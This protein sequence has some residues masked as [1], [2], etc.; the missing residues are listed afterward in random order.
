MAENLLSFLMLHLWLHQASQLAIGLIGLGCAIRAK[1]PQRDATA[2]K[3]NC[4]LVRQ[5]RQWGIGF[6]VSS[7]PSTV[8]DFKQICPSA[9][10]SVK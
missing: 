2:H 9:S 10:L 6:P 4:G 8:W 5:G 1:A 7:A 3:Q